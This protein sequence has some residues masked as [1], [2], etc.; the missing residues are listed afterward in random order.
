MFGIAGRAPV[1]TV[2]PGSRQN[3]VRSTC[4]SSWRWSTASKGHRPAHRPS[5]RGGDHG[6]GLLCAP[7]REGTNVIPVRGLPHDCLAYS[8]A[9]LIAS[10]SAT[11]EAAILGVPSVVLYRIS[12]LSYLI[13]RMV[14]QVSHISLPN[15]IAGREVFPEF[16]QSLDAEKIAKTVVS[17]VNNDRSAVQKEM[18]ELRKA[19]AVPGRDPYRIAGAEILRLLEQKNGPLPETA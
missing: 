6:R 8:D 11:L 5:A 17:M 16:I 1:I 9:A 19:L 12:A 4:P 10:G 2:M 18:E 14:V 7:S 15:I 3:E 13:A